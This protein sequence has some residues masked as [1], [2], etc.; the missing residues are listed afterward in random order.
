MSCVH[1]RCSK[2]DFYTEICIC[3]EH[4]S[5][6]DCSERRSLY[7]T[8]PFIRTTQPM[9]IIKNLTQNDRNDYL[10]WLNINYGISKLPNR[11]QQPLTTP[12]L[13]H[14]YS[15]IKM[16]TLFEKNLLDLF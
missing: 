10:N 15:R 2:T 8:L 7:K 12:I 16:R 1:G 11:F 4:W 13:A 5:G 3:D 9:K 6:I 14:R